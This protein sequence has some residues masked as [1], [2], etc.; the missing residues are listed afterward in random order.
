[1]GHLRRAIFGFAAWLA[2]TST[3]H[4]DPLSIGIAFLVNIGYAGTITA[5][6][7]TLVGAAILAAGAVGL[8]LLAGGLVQQQVQQAK[9]SERQ[10]TVR[11]AVGPRVRFYGKVKVGGTLWFFDTSSTSSPFA[12]GG[13]DQGG[14]ILYVGITLNE[15]EINSVEEIWL[16]DDLCTFD[17]SGFIT[18]PDGY[19]ING[20]TDPVVYQSIKMG[21]A[22]Q[23]VHSQLNAAFTVVTSDHRLRGVANILILFAEVNAD[24]VK[25]TYPDYIPKTRVVIEASLVKR[26]RTGITGYSDNAS[27]VIYDY[28]TG[29]DPAGFAYGAGLAESQIDLASFQA[30]ANVCDQPVD[31]KAGGVV[32]RYNLAGGFGLNEQMR[33]VLPRM[34]SAC[35][36][37]LYMTAEGKVGIR[38]GV[39]IEPTLTLDDSLGHIISGEF[40]KGQSALAAFNELTTLYTEPELDY[41]ESEAQV[42]IDTDNLALRGTVLSSQLEVIMAPNHS[43]ARRLAKIHTHKQNPRWVGTIITNYYGLNAIGER[44]MTLKFSP[45]GIDE[46]FMITG[47]RILDN[48]AGMELNVSSLSEDAYDWDAA[49]EEGDGPSVPPDTSDGVVTG[50]VTSVVGTAGVGQVNITW[51]QPS[52]ANVSG[53]RIFRN[54]VNTFGT[55]TR[56]A[57][58]YGGA[59]ANLAYLDAVPAGTYYYWVVAING[60]GLQAT[61]VAT[62]A[63]SPT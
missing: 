3:A 6:G 1:M 35:D 17:G 15:G 24:F 61:E 16:N 43:Q 30:F 5:L 21:T 29:V 22:N 52:D 57:T 27:D 50:P 47:M 20:D 36:A 58:V 7:A 45:L 40:R 9:P 53:A 41:Q 51:T 44:T 31:L 60:S 19:L 48:L 34:L 62:G 37:D 8:S 10:N 55:A 54:T 49:T 46:T 18:A 25:S 38:G 56:I 13:S 59:L 4:A 32:Q 28:L 12:W 42:W 23:T 11:Q 2:A 26:V 63:K 33:A 14:S 39:W